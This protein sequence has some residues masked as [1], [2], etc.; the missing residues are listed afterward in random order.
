[1]SANLDM[2]L[3]R[4]EG[5]RRA[6]EGYSARC[7]AHRDRSA[8][9]SIGGG[10][11]GRI[12]LHCFAGCEIGDILGALSLTVG[13]L[14][15]ERLRQDTPTERRQRRI[16]ARQHQWAAALPV[17]D[18]ETRIVLLICSDILK[19]LIPDDGDLERLAMAQQRIE[20]I[21]EQFNPVDVR[22]LLRDLAA[23]ATGAPA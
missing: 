17:L 7:P 14:F 16:A 6:G 9:L 11:D 13:D 10:T 21:R 4:L 2:L 3:A 18:F 15:P 23:N 20:D 5:V 19:G 8:S 12:L 22:K 1:M